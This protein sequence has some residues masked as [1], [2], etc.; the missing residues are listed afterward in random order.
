MAS[1]SL[2]MD[3]KMHSDEDSKEVWIIKKEQ[4]LNPADLIFKEGA[5]ELF[6]GLIIVLTSL[7]MFD[8]IHPGNVA[9]QS[10]FLLAL[11]LLRINP[12]HA[13][14]PL[15]GAMLIWLMEIADHS[16][17]SGILIY[18]C[19][20]YAVTSR[21]H[22]IAT[23]MALQWLVFG[24]LITRDFSPRRDDIP[25][26]IFE[27]LC[28]AG[29]TTIGVYRGMAK[30][31]EKRKQVA[32]QQLQKDLNSNIARYLH[33]NMARSLTMIVMHA[34]LSKGNMGDADLQNHLHGIADSGRSAIEDL[35]ELVSHLLSTHPEETGKGLGN[36]SG[37][38]VY[39]SISSATA[40]LRNAGYIVDCTELNPNICLSR[41]S[42]TAFTL[43]FNEVTVNLVKHALPHSKV[44]ID[45]YNDQNNYL[46]VSVSNTYKKNYRSRIGIGTGIGMKS[47][48][49]R[50]QSI[51][52]SAEFT[53]TDN[54]WH[55]FLSMPSNRDEEF[56]QD[57]NRRN[58]YSDQQ[59]VHNL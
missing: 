6:G 50:M 17:L 5:V 45:I 27:L 34:E 59:S 15:L 49:A 11:V 16:L 39:E 28:F 3:L 53:N 51:G 57:D 40:T 52:G 20:E 58:P 4:F 32:Q 14:L 18:L 26:V 30:S 55:V 12:P 37:G 24:Y 33:D 42:E 48:A 10:C 21:K 29:A 7:L 41:D 35:R 2:L 25:G 31:E 8:E 23:I 38:N 36:W 19:I 43:A 22:I 44:E 47:I 46:I 56:Y 9:L 13:P 54:R 1:L